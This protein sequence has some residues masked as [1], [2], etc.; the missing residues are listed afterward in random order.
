M[1]GKKKLDVATIRAGVKEQRKAEKKAFEKAGTAQA[2]RERVANAKKSGI[3]KASKPS[4][5]SSNRLA[6][7]GA[8]GS[9]R[10]GGL[11]LKLTPKKIADLAGLEMTA[12]S[13]MVIA[14]KAQL[15]SIPE[16]EE[17]D[18][19]MADGVEEGLG[20]SEDCYDP[21]LFGGE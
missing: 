21:E 12:D 7:G 5:R 10:K 8:L 2:V 13:P 6:G 11:K 9:M 1:F 14:A 19:E 4:S 3:S 17:D 16:A 18:I 15:P 20:E